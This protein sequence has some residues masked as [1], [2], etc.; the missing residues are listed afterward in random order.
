MIRAETLMNFLVNSVKVREVKD[1]FIIP[2]T[3]RTFKK[4]GNNS[5][6]ADKCIYVISCNIWYIYMY[7]TLGKHDL[8]RRINNHRPQKKTNTIIRPVGEHFNLSGHKLEDTTA[9]FVSD[10]RQEE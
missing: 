9:M 4:F 6:R 7:N 3:D 8:R 1:S 2:I 5:C 10:R